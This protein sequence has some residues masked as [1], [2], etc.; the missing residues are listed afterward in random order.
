MF[1]TSRWSESPVLAQLC[2]RLPRGVSILADMTYAWPLASPSTHPSI[3]HLRIPDHP[4]SNKIV[5]RLVP[6]RPTLCPS[7]W[8]HWPCEPAMAKFTASCN[9]F[10][11]KQTSLQQ[12]PSTTHLHHKVRS[13]LP[14]V[15]R[16]ADQNPRSSL[17][18]ALSNT[19][20]KPL[21]SCITPMSTPQPITPLQR[22]NVCDTIGH[23]VQI[24]TWLDAPAGEWGCS[25]PSHA[26]HF[27]SGTR[28]HMV[29]WWLHT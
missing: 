23:K 14:L 4:R 12:P 16:I 22:P 13:G 3:C 21:I 7:S 17:V 9:A 1:I 6:H 15:S 10:L 5:E 29:W 18:K 19:N 8:Q 28:M 25:V 11:N 27:P 2:V 20:K 24:V 26:R